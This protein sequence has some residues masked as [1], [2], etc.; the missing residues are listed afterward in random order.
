MKQLVI[1]VLSL[2]LSGSSDAVMAARRVKVK[3]PPD[4]QKELKE[5]LNRYFVN[6]YKPGQV[7]RSPAHLSSLSINDSLQTVEISADTYF[8]EQV[9]SPIS[10]DQIYHDVQ[11]LLPDTLKPYQLS[12]KTGGWDIRQLVPNRLLPELDKSRLWGDINYEGEPWVKNTSI[13]YKITDGLANRHLCVWAS[14][15]RYYDIKADIWKWQRPPLFG[16]REDL[17]TQTIVVPYLIP[18]LEK[19]GAVVFTPRERDWQRNEVIVDNDSPLG[20]NEISSRHCPWVQTDS[21]GFGYHPEPYVD[22][23]NPFKLGSARK[24]HV[25]GNGSRLSLISYQPNIPEAGRYAVYVSYQTV[26]GSIDDAH[27]TVWHQGIPT[28]FCV[29]Q[30]MGGSTWVYLGTFDFDE[31]TSV[32][33]CVVLSNKSRH[34]KGVVTADAVRFGGGM[35]NIERGSGTSHLPRCLEGSR[36]YAQWAGM[37]WE[38]YS[39]KDG[40]DDYGDDINAR[41]YMANHLA[42]GSVYMPDTIGQHVPLELSLAVHSDAGFSR[43][44]D[45]TGTLSICTTYLNDSI[46]GTGMTRLASRDLADELL[47]TVSAEM[48]RLYGRWTMRELYDRNYSESRCPYVPSAILETL[49]HQNFNDMRYGQDPNFRFN[50]ARSIYKVLLRYIARMHQTNYVVTPLAPSHLRTEITG[51]GK[52]RLSW[53]PVL[54]PDEPTAAPEGYIVYTAIGKNGFDNG[55]YIKG[56]KTSY[57]LN[58]EPGMVYSFRVA[59]VNAGGESFP[60]E[61]VSVCDIPG[62]Q[63]S[64]LIVNGFQRLASPKVINDEKRQGFDLEADAGVSYGRTAGWLGFQTNFDKSAIGRGGVN[65]LGYTNDSLMGQFIAGND[66]NYIRTH[67]DAIATSQRYAIASCSRQALMD[68]DIK[69]ENYNLIDLILGLERN[70]GYSLR[71]GEAFPTLLRNQLQQFTAKGGSLLVSGSYVGRDMPLINDS[72]WLADVLKCDFGGTDTDNLQRDSIRGMG[73]EFQFYRHLNEQHYAATHPD[74]LMPIA[75]AYSAMLYADDYSACV[76]YD[77]ADYRAFTMGF[78]FECIES[79]RMRQSL[80]RGILNFLLK[81]Q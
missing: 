65:G 78:P 19:A 8:G 28:E 13:P 24:A 39:T 34:H 17:F 50:F 42:G 14:H 33:N 79:E 40:E 15:G 6:Y 31:G 73:T 55:T 46:L 80:M 21:A 5:K 26:E 53:R 66:F 69:T 67:A 12:I 48:Q 2:I 68:G 25:G 64:I 41:S 81:T 62:A 51:E 58:V 72:I 47:T 44:G 18:M 60:S 29:N 4:P 45:I 77:G 38:V 1:L 63:K 61:L 22:H 37:P 10:A 36:Y 76:A 7:L 32:R 9:F 3:T 30:Q 75:P 74:I 52:A 59:A 23:E 35:G 16:T 20:Y 54:D 11:D 43:N 71:R 27:Y 70:D 49:S 57:S 56:G